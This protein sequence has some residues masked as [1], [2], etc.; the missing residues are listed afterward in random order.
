MICMDREKILD[1]YLRIGEFAVFLRRILREDTPSRPF[2]FLISFSY[3]CFIA[4]PYQGAQNVLL[5][6]FS[7][8]SHTFPSFA[9]L[10]VAFR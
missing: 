5:S 3:P 6:T 4:A 2:R 7:Y 8:I 9:R 10:P 1:Y